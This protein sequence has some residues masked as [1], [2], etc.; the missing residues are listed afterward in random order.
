VINSSTSLGG[1]ASGA[2][3]R[4]TPPRILEELV[5]PACDLPVGSKRPEQ[6]HGDAVELPDRFVRAAEV[7]H[8]A[9]AEPQDDPDYG[10]NSTEEHQLPDAEDDEEP[11]DEPGQHHE[12]LPHGAD[13]FACRL[14]DQPRG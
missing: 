4:W 12:S 6:E 2:S 3:L 8:H 11:N 5:Q 14:C 1:A 10:E 13:S 9:D 7:K